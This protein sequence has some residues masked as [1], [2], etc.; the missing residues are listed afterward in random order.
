MVVDDRDVVRPCVGPAKENAPLGVD[1]NRV[2]PRHPSDFYV[3]CLS[4]RFASRLFDDFPGGSCLIIYDAQ[5][6]DRR[7]LGA[8]KARFPEWFVTAFGMSYIDP[9]NPGDEPI[10]LPR[11][12]HMRYINQQEQRI[13]CHPRTPHRQV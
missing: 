12:K 6:F 10:L 11:A 5:E 7:V 13:L 4:L 1:S 8:L 2:K 3:Q 9:N